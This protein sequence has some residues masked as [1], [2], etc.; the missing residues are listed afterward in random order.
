M[1]RPDTLFGSLKPGES[2][3]LALAFAWTYQTGQLLH[4]QT[5]ILF[6]K[7]FS[8]PSSPCSATASTSLAM[9]R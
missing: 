8:A 6:K 7:H 9:S 1:M 4:R 2:R 5:P 3:L